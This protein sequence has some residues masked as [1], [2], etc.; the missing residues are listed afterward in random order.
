MTSV[1]V[2]FTGPIIY[3]CIIN[4]FLCTG[5]RQQLFQ[6]SGILWARNSDE[7]QEDGFSLPVMSGEP[8]REP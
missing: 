5:V 3:F 4:H 6:D 7:T 8:T 1:L 2:L